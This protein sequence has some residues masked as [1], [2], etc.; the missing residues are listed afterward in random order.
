LPFFVYVT[1][2]ENDSRYSTNNTY[3]GFYRIV[4]DAKH[5]GNET[6][7]VPHPSTWF[8]HLERR[9][10]PSSRNPHHAA[11][12]NPARQ[13]E[14]GSDDD[15]DGDNDVEIE[16][17]RISL[18]CP[19]TLLTFENPVKNS[20]CVH[21]FERQAIEDMIKAGSMTVPAGPNDFQGGAASGGR[22]ARARRVRAAPCPVCSEALTLND[23]EPDLVLLRRVR[24]ARAAELREQEDSE[25]G[26]GRPERRRGVMIESDE[27]PD[28]S[29]DE[30]ARQAG[31]EQE[32][33]RIRIKR[34]RS[35]M[36]STAPTVADNSPES[37]EDE[38]DE[39]SNDGSDS[40]GGS[41]SSD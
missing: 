16:R 21:S 23:L 37:E 27:H 34:E 11:P 8:S 17:E 28:T 18:K 22:N 41:D 19:L 4:H 32:Q 2:H 26:S 35:R 24:R 20:K 5:P 31:E 6:P 38:E 10:A 14:E 13:Q 3:V 30:E 9:H 7:P 39:E 36:S 25:L 1:N 29:D 15:D 12:S 33:E 40:R